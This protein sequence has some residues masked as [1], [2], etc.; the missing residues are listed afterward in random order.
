[1]ETLV[2]VLRLLSLDGEGLSDFAQL[3]RLHLMAVDL[4]I[5]ELIRDHLYGETGEFSFGDPKVR[6]WLRRN[7]ERLDRVL[8]TLVRS[9]NEQKLKEFLMTLEFRELYWYNVNPESPYCKTYALNR[10]YTNT[11]WIMHTSDTLPR[12]INSCIDAKNTTELD[13]WMMIPA[14]QFQS[15]NSPL[16]HAVKTENWE[17]VVYMTTH[18]RFSTWTKCFLSFDSLEFCTK[19]K[20]C[21][22]VIPFDFKEELLDTDMYNVSSVIPIKDVPGML[23]LGM[24]ID[25][26]IDEHTPWFLDTLWGCVDLRLGCM[27]SNQA[28]Y[29]MP[30]LEAFCAHGAV[31]HFKDEVSVLDKYMYCSPENVLRTVEVMSLLRGYGCEFSES[32]I[33]E[34]WEK[35]PDEMKESVEHALRAVKAPVSST[36]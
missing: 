31:E 28:E 36:D 30:A 25:Y 2:R 11:N 18:P 19:V 1:M 29:Y 33:K 5:D 27:K 7:H 9:H 23:D 10:E 12:L 32:F 16:Q 17:M 24:P 4:Y 35:T 13:L 22:G 20:A 3:S 14:C 15:G 8:C 26:M 6:Y 21:G 34:I